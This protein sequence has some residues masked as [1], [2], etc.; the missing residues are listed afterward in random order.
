MTVQKEMGFKRRR[1]RVVCRR[2]FKTDI[3]TGWSASSSS[4]DGEDD[5]LAYKAQWPKETEL[6]G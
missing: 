1:V 6:R 3:P 2:S 4:G 5:V